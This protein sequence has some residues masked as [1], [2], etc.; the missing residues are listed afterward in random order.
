MPA[1]TTANQVVDHTYLRE[2]KALCPG[3]TFWHTCTALSEATALLFWS[4][5]PD[6]N[7]ILALFYFPRP[8]ARLPVFLVGG[9]NTD[10][11]PHFSLQ[12]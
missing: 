1:R 10:Q 12:V 2:V 11:R 3:A 6:M 9:R 5:G 4:V 7:A 8:T